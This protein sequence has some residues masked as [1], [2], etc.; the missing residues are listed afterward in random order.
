M[1]GRSF[2]RTRFHGIAEGYRSGLEK[3]I[4]KELDLKKVKYEYEPLRIPFTPPAKKRTY[5]PDIIL[6][7]SLIIELKGRFL[8]E[9]RQKHLHIKSEYPL[10][11]LR[12][13]FQNP[14][15]PINTGSKTSYAKWCDT[16]GFLWAKNTIPQAWIDEP[17]HKEN[18]RLLSQLRK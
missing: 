18:R 1:A 16:H 14:N 13:V 2:G 9:D 8:S 17:T 7:N 15:A 10:I 4:C 3:T 12:F 5:T 6:D 11:D